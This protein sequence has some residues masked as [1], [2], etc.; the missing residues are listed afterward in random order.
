VKSI[1][2]EFKEMREEVQ[3]LCNNKPRK[4]ANI[5][6][7]RSKV[8]REVYNTTGLFRA[9]PPVPKKPKGIL[10][11]YGHFAIFRSNFALFRLFF[12]FVTAPSLECMRNE[13]QN[14][15]TGFR[16]QKFQKKENFRSKK[17][18]KPKM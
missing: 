18:R 9:E 2:I 1:L 13:F 8:S 3:T 14:N 16:S 17:R 12:S 6:L 7:Q 5:A 4:S 10:P 11:M 15:K